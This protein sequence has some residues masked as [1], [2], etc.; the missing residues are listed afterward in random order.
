MMKNLPVTADH[1]T[2]LQAWRTL[3]LEKIPY[4]AD[5]IFNLRPVNK[6]GL[7]TMAVDKHLRLY[8][9][10]EA[11]REWGAEA[12]S[13][14][15]LHE[16]LHIFGDHADLAELTGV[17]PHDH[18]VWNVAADASIN[19][20]LK[21]LAHI[22]NTG[23]LPEQFGAPDH[24]TAPEYFRILKDLTDSNGAEGDG[25]EHPDFSGCGDGAGGMPIP[26]ALDESDDMDGHA[27]A[28]TPSEKKIID[29]NVATA[30]ATHEAQNPGSLSGDLETRIQQIFEPSR[31]KWKTLLNLE[32]RKAHRLVSG[33]VKRDRRKRNRRAHARTISVGG[34]A[35]KMIQ[36]GWARPAVSVH[37]VRDT[38]VSMLMDTG[39]RS[40]LDLV[41]REIEGIARSM[42]I[43]GKDLRITDFDVTAHK[44]VD[45]NGQQSVQNVAGL[46]GTDMGAAVEHCV[47][48]FAPDVLVVMT[49][50]ETGWPEEKP[51]HTHVIACILSDD[52]VPDY[53]EPPSWVRVV[54]V[55]NDG[56]GVPTACR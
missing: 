19:D 23:V 55:R 5:L 10:F 52:P 32:I 21:D 46:G 11:V 25:Q 4:F 53:F 26:G 40:S 8:I 22:T 48:E 54:R 50:G 28:A 17:G 43:K 12:C 16:C 18:K 45:W 51:A 34:T 41:T 49:D 31:V 37:V 30:L 2:D 38:S 44:T 6:P 29:I 13:Q 7:G 36:P 15:L 35:R 27:P 47:A 39:G 33:M 14:V 20:D 9:D 56:T 42:R 1:L 24:L 3:A